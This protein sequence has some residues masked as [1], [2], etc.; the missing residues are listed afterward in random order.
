LPRFAK[1][2]FS[3][4]FNCPPD[5]MRNAALI[6]I[7]GLVFLVAIAL[8]STDAAG[9]DI[10]VD[11]DNAYPWPLQDG[12][13]DRPYDSIQR[14]V[15]NANGGDHILVHE[16]APYT[17][18]VEHV[19][20][21]VSVIITGDS[22]DSVEVFHDGTNAVISI[23]ASGVTIESMTVSGD[24]NPM[25]GVRVNPGGAN[26]VIRDCVI[27]SL[28][29]GVL[30]S[31]ADSVEIYSNTMED[32][33]VGQ[34]V[35]PDE[36]VAISL[37]QA[38][39]CNIYDNTATDTDYILYMWGDEQQD[40]DHIVAGSNTLDGKPVRYYHDL[41]G[42]TISFPDDNISFLGFYNCDGITVRDTTLN[43]N[44]FGV[45]FAGCGNISVEDSTFRDGI[46]GVWVRFS[47]DVKISGCELYNQSHT[48][49]TVGRSE[50]FLIGDGNRIEE[51][52]AGIVIHGSSNGRIYD[53]E[54]A[55]F[56]YVCMQ[57][58]DGSDS[59]VVED[60]SFSGAADR[61]C[62]L[63]SGSNV[64]FKGNEFS[65][66]QLAIHC[67]GD[68][69]NNIIR[70][71]TF[72]GSAGSTGIRIEGPGHNVSGN[73]F[74][75]GLR[76][77]STERPGTF[78]ANDIQD[79][80]IGIQFYQA[81]GSVLRGA[82]FQGCDRAI[83][84]N[85]SEI[86]IEECTFSSNEIDI[87]LNGAEIDSP[88]FNSTALNTPIDPTKLN[89][90]GNCTL[91]EQNPL[92]V[93]VTDNAFKPLR[94]AEMFV[95]NID[96]E[97]NESTIFYA[98]PAY[99]GSNGTTPGSGEIG[100]LNITY[101]EHNETGFMEFTCRINA[102]YDGSEEMVEETMDGEMSIEIYLDAAAPE[103]RKPGVLI[104]SPESNEVVEGTIL[105]KGTASDPDGD[106][107]LEKVEIR[108][109]GGSWRTAPGTTTWE[110]Q[111]DTTSKA[112]GRY[113][114]EARAYDGEDYSTA[115]GIFILIDNIEN[116]PPEITELDIDRTKVTAGKF[117]LL[118]GTLMDEDGEDDIDDIFIEVWNEDGIMVKNL[119]GFSVIVDYGDPDEYMD[120]TLNFD[121][122]RNWKGNYVLRV[123][124]TDREGETDSRELSFRVNEKK[125]GNNEIIEGIDDDMLFYGIIPAI[126]VGAAAVVLGVYFFRKSG[127]EEGYA[128]PRCGGEAD[129]IE[130]YDAYYCWNCEEYL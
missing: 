23:S 58:N 9:Q 10:H 41:S 66:F 79:A 43:G 123:T 28:T 126:A 68:A 84:A 3:D 17:P 119:T 70:D 110:Y 32:I 29:R 55:T 90:D 77:I 24:G 30:V 33:H 40:Y 95:R 94:D 62:Q 34:G 107:T 114:I 125:D 22:T 108:I 120:F 104:T 59:V 37:D 39:S 27:R 96:G 7:T 81:T 67:Q 121:A 54:L 117:L 13:R 25:S 26:S 16:D 87:E 53:N 76:A 46:G 109:G 18:Y 89:I 14:G 61:C 65:D 130:D 82:S 45:H 12:S 83:V 73:T 11:K 86:L 19:S 64:T 72:H 127:G 56:D 1:N 80:H 50:D 113:L 47:S 60:N 21:D 48:S 49:I 101:R 6:L 69:E 116:T 42:E 44:S 92:T 71:N 31:G 88:H 112:D 98:T 93:T 52:S 118:T 15:D 35:L 115:A 20:V 57:I 78:G 106:E 4:E 51:G 5:S 91:F 102:S 129:Y 2:Y 103:N 128:C 8:V 38:T 100:P 111:F 75:G 122:D 105:I 63:W 97:G 74:E 99:G 124:I 36:G 85:E